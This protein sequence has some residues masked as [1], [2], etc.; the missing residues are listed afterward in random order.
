MVT[1]REFIDVCF[2]GLNFEQVSCF[3]IETPRILYPDAS[4][5]RKSIFISEQLLPGHALAYLARFAGSQTYF[6]LTH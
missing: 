2:G 1:K 4:S 3:G 5:K 6:S